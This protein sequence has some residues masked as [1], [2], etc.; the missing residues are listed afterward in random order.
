MQSQ[1]SEMKSSQ[2]LMIY[3]FIIS[4]YVP[5]SIM[6]TDVT[7]YLFR[8]IDIVTIYFTISLLSSRGNAREPNLQ[9]IAR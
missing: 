7:K 9:H 1:R 5:L 8:N 4:S 6:T 3:L 2:S